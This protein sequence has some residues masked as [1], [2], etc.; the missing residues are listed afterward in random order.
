MLYGARQEGEDHRTQSL[1]GKD[2]NILSFQCVW[3]LVLSFIGLF[4]AALEKE[5]FS[6]ELFGKMFEMFVDAHT[7]E[8]CIRITLTCGVI[9][10]GRD[11]IL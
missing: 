5:I 1:R 7:I 10:F 4:V 2:M 6:N 8:K 11:A 3:W 9:L